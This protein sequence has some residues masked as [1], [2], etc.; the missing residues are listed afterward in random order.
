MIADVFQL[1]SMAPPILM[2]PEVLFPRILG[3]WELEL[4]L[5]R[6]SEAEAPEV[7]ASAS[8]RDCDPVKPHL[9]KVADPP[10]VWREVPE[11]VSV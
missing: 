1:T 6:D 7:T 11:G 5:E 3:V 2:A 9:L 8:Q 10:V 4:E